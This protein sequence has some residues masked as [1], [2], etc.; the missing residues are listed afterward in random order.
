[1]AVELVDVHTF[2]EPIGLR[3]YEECFMKN[4]WG[5]NGT[6]LNRKRLA[7]LEIS[8]LCSMNIHQHD[9]QKLIMARVRDLSTIPSMTLSES[10]SGGKNMVYEK[11]TSGAQ[12]NTPA[13]TPSYDE[14]DENEA[15]SPR[16]R[17][18]LS[19]TGSKTV[20]RSGAAQDKAK[21]LDDMR[22]RS[23][24]MI[25]SHTGIATLN[26]AL[27]SHKDGLSSPGG[28][29]SG[30]RPSLS[31]R[32]SS[33]GAGDVPPTAAAAAR[34]KSI[35]YGNKALRSNMLMNQLNEL[36]ETVLKKLSATMR[37]DR[38]TLMF[39]DERHGELF[40]FDGP[41]CIR[42]PMTKGLSGHCAMTGE[43]LLVNDPYND[44]RFNRQID[45]DTGFVTR[46]ILCEPVKSRNSTVL[47]VL[48][49]VNK[50]GGDEFTE[51]DSDVME[52]AVLKVSEALDTK[53]SE[54]ITLQS[55]WEGHNPSQA[56]VPVR[57]TSIVDSANVAAAKSV[58]MMNGGTQEGSMAEQ[59]DKFEFRATDH[60]AAQVTTLTAE[61][62]AD[63]KKAERRKSYSKEVRDS[64]IG[65]L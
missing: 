10:K 61:N 32:R 40:F 57:R 21:K 18:S 41:A 14:Y 9:H 47:G 42:F 1:M 23:S 25:D 46:N 26:L 48:Q 34:M 24:I 33:V 36:K 52:M 29:G 7:A 55:E 19:S 56:T 54:L 22:H 43:R 64:N 17:A 65:L 28:Q 6:G 27:T 53:F 12:K 62:A 44:E 15:G 37:C 16:R 20:R 13:K 39:L 49:M 8:H 38:A 59:V 30:R 63:A 4:L 50:K 11:S 58:D 5:G 35:E 31:K 3:Q 45:K 51:L 60:K 2:L